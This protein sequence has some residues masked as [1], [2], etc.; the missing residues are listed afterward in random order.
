MITEKEQAGAKT[1]FLDP[2]SGVGKRELAA[3]WAR[4]C[5][6]VVIG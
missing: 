4:V 6:R 2:I 1:P 3:I 5:E